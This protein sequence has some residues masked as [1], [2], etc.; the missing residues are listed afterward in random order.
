MKFAAGLLCLALASSGAFAAGSVIPDEFLPLLK[1]KTQI[2]EFVSASL[3]LDESGSGDR[4]GQAVNPRLGGTRIAPY[5]VKAKPK[6]E[7]KWSLLLEIQAT[8]EFLDDNGRRT[9]IHT[10][11]SVRETFTGIRISTLEE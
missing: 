2:F 9:E 10:A 11:S 3:D 4:I 7:K 8:V 1:Q 5:F 6:G